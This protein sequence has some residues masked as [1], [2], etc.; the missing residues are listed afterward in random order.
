MDWDRGTWNLSL[1]DHVRSLIARRK[2][3]LALRQGDFQP[4]IADDKTGV[5]AFA[6]RSG[7]SVAIVVVN[8]S[9]K[10][11]K[12][13]LPVTAKP[14]SRRIVP[15]APWGSAVICQDG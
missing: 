9:G 5:F 12:V 4:L 1:F 6:R 8:G 13:S 15:L 14:F 2:T 11:R 7:R 10:A 3:S